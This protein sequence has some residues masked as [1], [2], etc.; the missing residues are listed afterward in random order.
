M[1]RR[2]ELV[3]LLLAAGWAR[4]V[5]ADPARE[6]GV[7]CEAGE[8]RDACGCSAGGLGWMRFY[9]RCGARLA[10]VSCVSFDVCPDV[11]RSLPAACA[12]H[13]ASCEEHRA[14]FACCACAPQ[15]FHVCP[16][17]YPTLSLA[18]SCCDRT[19]G[20]QLSPAGFPRRR[21][22]GVQLFASRSQQPWSAPFKSLAQHDAGV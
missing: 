4:C 17:I 8:P 22:A 1:L 15:S 20:V 14:P 13:S 5:G 11:L 2:M 7:R 9:S 19:S 3:A 18:Q 21:P 12:T 6:F 16:L 10:S